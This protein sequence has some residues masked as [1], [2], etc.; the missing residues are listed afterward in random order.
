MMCLCSTVVKVVAWDEHIDSVA[1]L[2]QGFYAFP[3]IVLMSTMKP[4]FING[5]TNFPTCLFNKYVY[6]LFKS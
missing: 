4:R 2:L 6:A 3:L 1:P 5:Y